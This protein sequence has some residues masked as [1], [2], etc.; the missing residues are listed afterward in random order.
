MSFFVTCCNLLSLIVSL[1]MPLVVS[2][3]V[4]CCHSIYHSPT[5]LSAILEKHLKIRKRHLHV[6]SKMNALTKLKTFKE[7]VESCCS[8][9]VNPSFSLK[10]VSIIDILLRNI[11]TLFS[12]KLFHK[13]RGVYLLSEHLFV[14]KQTLAESSSRKKL[15]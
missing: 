7:N 12:R 4:I 14:Q 6:V 11:S 13:T 5:F 3:V 9:F 15:F 10:R 8:R 1:Q 2:L